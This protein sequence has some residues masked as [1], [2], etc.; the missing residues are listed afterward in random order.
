M[1]GAGGRG[2][3]ASPGGYGGRDGGTGGGSGG[4]ALVHVLFSD[5]MLTPV[6]RKLRPLSDGVSPFGPLQSGSVHVSMGCNGSSRP[7]GRIPKPT[8]IQA[9]FMN[10]K[11]TERALCRSVRS[12]GPPPNGL[13][14]P[15][16]ERVDVNDDFVPSTSSKLRSISSPTSVSLKPSMMSCS[17]YAPL[18]A[19]SKS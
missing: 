11:L 8:L 3:G 18:F 15:V 6:N 10:L 5:A 19:L 9:V 2:S 4:K 7:A 17:K 14:L 12:S 13:S 16:P 1:G